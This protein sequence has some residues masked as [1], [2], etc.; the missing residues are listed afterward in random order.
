MPK[1]AKVLSLLLNVARSEQPLGRG[2]IGARTDKTQQSVQTPDRKHKSA[3][4][5]LKAAV[6]L[7]PIS[8]EYYL[9]TNSE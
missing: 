5:S 1:L 8:L 7:N 4:V 6:T 9:P 2:Y 3:T